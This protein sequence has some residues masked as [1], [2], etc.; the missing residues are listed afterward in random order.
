[1]PHELGARTQADLT[2]VVA[3]LRTRGPPG[4][5]RVA[6]GETHLRQ[7]RHDARPRERLREEDHPGVLGP[8]TGDEPLPERNRLRVGVVDAEDAYAVAAPVVDDLLARRPHGQPLAVGLG[9]EVERVDVLVALR[10]V[11]GGA[12][13]AVRPVME[14]RRVLAYPGV[15]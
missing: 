6:L 7:L 4:E 8:D 2:Q 12:D 14:P 3:Q 13:G 11:L 5:V 9:P 15:I 10:G 1:R